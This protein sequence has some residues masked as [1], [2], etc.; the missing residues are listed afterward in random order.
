MEGEHELSP[1]VLA[2]GVLGA[3]GAQQGDG[4]AVLPSLH[5]GGD[6]LA[7]GGEPYLGKGG[8]AAR[9]QGMVGQVG[10]RDAAPQR[11]RLG[12]RLGIAAGH[13]TLERQQVELVMSH[14]DQ[15]AGPL[16]ADAGT[17]FGAQ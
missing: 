10:Q 3:Q 2:E 14:L 6:Q 17:E 8:E 12:Q 1:Q 13:Q 11:Q 4:L 5:A 16:G 9:P 15:V 7:C